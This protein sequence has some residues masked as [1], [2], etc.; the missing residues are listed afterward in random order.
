MQ[1]KCIPRLNEYQSRR[2][3]R[4]A[5]TCRRSPPCPPGAGDVSADLACGQSPP[6]HQGPG[7]HAPLWRGD[8]FLCISGYVDSK[9]VYNFDPFLTGLR[10]FCL[11]EKTVFVKHQ[12]KLYLVDV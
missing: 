8:V 11:Y 2:G 5:L 3:M 7:A 12:Q 6:A 9:K 4:A 10:H 1:R